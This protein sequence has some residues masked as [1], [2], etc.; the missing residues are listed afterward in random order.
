MR[1]TSPLVSTIVGRRR[2]RFFFP[3]ILVKMW[4]LYAFKR[5][6]FPVPVME[7]RFLAPLC[8]FI[9][10]IGRSRIR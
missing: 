6:T 3:D 1:R 10:G 9:F 2:S 4:L 7:K 5:R 8:V